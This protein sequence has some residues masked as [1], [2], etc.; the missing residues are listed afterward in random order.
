MHDSRVL[1]EA[2]LKLTYPQPFYRKDAT[3]NELQ[4]ATTWRRTV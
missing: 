3:R 1:H 2:K 4:A